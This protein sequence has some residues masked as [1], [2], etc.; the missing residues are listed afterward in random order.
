MLTIYYNNS[1]DYS[2]RNRFYDKVEGDN[3]SS[4]NAFL[5][6]S[7][8]D[9]YYKTNNRSQTINFQTA[10]FIPLSVNNIGLRPG[11]FTVQPV[12]SVKKIIKTNNNNTPSV[13][14]N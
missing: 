14:R 5:S 1:S 7:S 10:D 9:L 2:N 8:V 11:S 4:Y 3:N 13:T 12:N 6:S